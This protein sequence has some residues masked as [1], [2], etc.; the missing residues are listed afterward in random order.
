MT[1]GPITYKP[2]SALPEIAALLDGAESNVKGDISSAKNLLANPDAVLP[3][4]VVAFTLK[5]ANGALVLLGMHAQ[6][7][8]KWQKDNITQA[9]RAEVTRLQA[10]VPQVRPL[11]Q[12]L[13][14]LAT[15]LE[16]RARTGSPSPRKKWRH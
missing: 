6:Q 2:I 11:I 1:S 3:L 5:E 14:A 7:L 12:R 4:D 8:S 15:E 9:E 13:I 10:I 16:T